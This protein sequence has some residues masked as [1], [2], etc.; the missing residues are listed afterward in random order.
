MRGLVLLFLVACRSPETQ[1]APAPS[2]AV[3]A[4]AAPI[5]SATP[6]ASTAPRAT[7]VE[8]GKIDNRA[9]ARLSRE[10]ESQQL[11]MLGGMRVVDRPLTNDN[12]NAVELANALTQAGTPPE[13]DSGARTPAMGGG[14]GNLTNLTMVGSAV[15]D[16]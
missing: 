6:S 3:A 16:H 8:G 14:G 7:T 5:V 15:R 13:R 4:S 2:A 10:L 12:P 1:P 11:Q 9:A